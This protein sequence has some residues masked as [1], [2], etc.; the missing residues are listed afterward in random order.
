MQAEI[1]GA[2]AVEAPAGEDDVFAKKSSREEE[3]RSAAAMVPPFFVL[4]REK[5]KSLKSRCDRKPSH[6]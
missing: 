1:P 6:S 5:A 3:F 4:A 2:A